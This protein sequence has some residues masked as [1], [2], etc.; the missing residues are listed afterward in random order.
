MEDAR[1]EEAAATDRPLRLRAEGADDLAVISSLAQ[2]AVAKVADVSWAKGRR[3]LVALLNRFRWEDRPEA[4]I[5][6]RPPERVRS[7]LTIEQVESVQAR[8][9]DPSDAETV[10]SILAIGFE[11]SD[12]PEDPSGVI[13]LH[14]AGDGDVAI[15]V[16]ALEISLEDVSRPWLAPSGKTPDH[17]EA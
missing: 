16:E 11:T 1:F 10:V 5:D 12:D 7:I 13:T 2:D 14:L 15:R 4:A 8:G 17:G 9:V 6:R 3:R